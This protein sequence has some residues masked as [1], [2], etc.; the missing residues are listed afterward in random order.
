MATPVRPGTLAD[1]KGSYPDAVNADFV[2]GAG[3]AVATQACAPILGN[4]RIGNN[5]RKT[6]DMFLVEVRRLED[7][8][9]SWE[10]CFPL[11]D[12]AGEQG[13]RPEQEGCCNMVMS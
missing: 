1:M 10:Y 8:E 2:A 5:R 11:A 12:T 9:Y 6:H 3:P 7:A 4:G 13:F